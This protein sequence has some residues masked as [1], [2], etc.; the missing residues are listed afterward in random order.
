[1]SNKKANQKRIVASVAL[2]MLLCG[3][4]LH[5]ERDVS[6]LGNAACCPPRVVDP[7]CYGYYPTCW[8]IWPDDCQM[9]VVPDGMASEIHE[10]EF[11]KPAHPDVPPLP[12]DPEQIHTPSPFVPNGVSPTLRTPVESGHREEPS[13]QQPSSSPPPPVLQNPNAAHRPEFWPPVS[14]QANAW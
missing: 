5:C 3:G 1:M 11:V 2:L 10:S 13:T 14:A 8:R 7:T 12:A 4:C 9:C 6:T